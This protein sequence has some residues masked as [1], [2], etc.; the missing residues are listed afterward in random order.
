MKW[1][2]EVLPRGNEA[3]FASG[4]LLLY[5]LELFLSPDPNW[6]MWAAQ[7]AIGVLYVPDAPTLQGIAHGETVRVLS[8]AGTFG[9]LRGGGSSGAADQNVKQA[10]PRIPVPS[11]GGDGSG[12]VKGRTEPFPTRKYRGGGWKAKEVSTMEGILFDIEMFTTPVTVLLGLVLLAIGACGILLGHM[13]DEE[14]S[15]KGIFWAESPFTDV[16]VS[17]TPADNVRY[18]RAA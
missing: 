3:I 4:L 1:I 5:A 13:A 7:M 16:G 15:G 10:A 11:G 17:E 18:L 12:I 8:A 14:A 2:R 6:T 9:S